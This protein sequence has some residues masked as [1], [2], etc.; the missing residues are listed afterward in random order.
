MKLC[1]S[2]LGC[3]EWEYGDIM[4]TAGDLGYDGVEIRGIGRNIYAPDIPQ[5]APDKI[6]AT[7][8][9]L[10]KKGLSI[11]CLTSDCLLHRPPFKERTLQEADAYFRLAGAL[12]VPYVRV[13]GDDPQPWP[14]APVD[15]G[16][17]TE[18]A[19][20][21]AG[22]AKKHNVTLLIETN[23]HFVHS[24]RLANLLAKIDRPNVA[25]L[26][27]IHHPYRYAG[28]S[29][30]VTYDNLAPWVRHVHIKDSTL[31]DRVRYTLTGQGDVPI[32]ECIA[33]LNK[34]GYQ[35]FYSLEWVRR[36]DLTLEMPGI[37]LAQY[38]M[39]MKEQ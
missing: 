23:G 39:W 36:W 11:P 21:L 7:R 32:R 6:E 14:G 28:E 5:F 4:A 1:F 33:L 10:A 34:G 24:Q 9:D 8:K 12:G 13:L 37:V 29:A 18:T 16:Y 15:E 26:W 27:D 17:V 20:E 2:T 22:I 31:T 3:P 35:G 30:Q 25:A 19:Q 38:I